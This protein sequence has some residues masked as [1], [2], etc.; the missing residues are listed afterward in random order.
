MS[1][2]L[3]MMVVCALSLAVLALGAVGCNKKSG[4]AAPSQ[5]NPTPTPFQGPT[6][7]SFETAFDGVSGWLTLYNGSGGSYAA[8]RVSGTSFMPTSGSWYLSMCAA[9]TNNWYSSAS[10]AYQDNV[11][12]SRS[13]TLVFDYQ[14][15]S[16]GNVDAEMLFTSSG[17]VT[18]WGISSTGTPINT[19]ALD[20]SVALPSLPNPG[21][22]TLQAHSTGG[23]GS[24]ICLF[25]DHIRVN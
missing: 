3:S 12:F 5:G 19:Q 7:P 21:K 17:T 24:S 10:G 25:I 8:G 22:L 2:R 9:G 16:A 6:N 1:K 14:A 23:A 13:T 4:P 20:V 18:L 11:D 15:A